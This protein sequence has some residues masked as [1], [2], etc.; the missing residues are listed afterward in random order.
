MSKLP[1]MD[2]AETLPYSNRFK[3]QIKSHHE[4]RAPY[5]ML[6]P[7]LGGIAILVYFPLVNTFFLSF[8]RYFWN[9]PQQPIRWVGL[10]NY[11]DVFSDSL[12]QQALTNTIVFMICSTLL[13]IV[14][15]LAMAM[16]FSRDFPGKN[17]FIA[18]VL[19]PMMIAPVAAALTWNF[20]FD[21]KWGGVN[22]FVHLLGFSKQAWLADPR[23]ALPAVMVADI[24][25]NAPFVFL[26]L[27]TSLQALPQEPIEAARIDG[28]T[29]WQIFTRVI[30]PLLIPN[31]LLIFIIRLMDTFRVFDLIYIMTNGGPGG[32]SETVGFLSYERTFRHF[33]MGQGS[34]IA[35]FILF[36]VLIIS[37]YFIR[38]LQ[39]QLQEQIK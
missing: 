22:Y 37:W 25:L 23:F 19:L 21:G 31:F 39:Q 24:W 27:Y 11:I 7:V 34:V 17:V 28:G 8:L 30:L 15:G 3:R 5:W 2:Q 32:R 4:H 36:S 16:M 38:T 14:I 18:L 9:K 26:V 33:N 35:I 29:G 12:F 1:P 13:S 6:A 10:K 20:L